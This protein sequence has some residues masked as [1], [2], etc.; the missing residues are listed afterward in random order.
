MTA[1]PDL[2]IRIDDA[3]RRYKSPD[4]A[5][6]AKR[7][8]NFLLADERKALLIWALEQRIRLRIAQQRSAT[9]RA[10]QERHNEEAIR[11]Q[12]EEQ[13][14]A[15]EEWE[16]GARSRSAKVQASRARIDDIIT[17]VDIGRLQRAAEWGISHF[18]KELGVSHGAAVRIAEVR[19]VDFEAAGA[20]RR[21]RLRDSIDN[22]VE[23]MKTEYRA[24][25]IR[26]ALLEANTERVCVGG[27]WMLLG[28]CEPEHLR[29]LADEYIA[30]AE[31]NAERA[32]YYLALA[33]QM[34][35]EGDGTV[36][37][38]AA[39]TTDERVAAC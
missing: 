28:D 27:E 5:S 17:N 39:R 4:P 2:S 36:R 11:V 9:I 31:G 30:R 6:I 34:D 26:I 12:E 16:R 1:P 8:H 18:A 23:E 7:M 10:E 14:R 19:H 22:A 38:M 15:R 21:K 25:G 32:A 20:Q 33:Q 37:D 29:K 3:L 24:Q 35:T 13:Q